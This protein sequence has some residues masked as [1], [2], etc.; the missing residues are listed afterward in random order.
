M[1][2]LWDE[3]HGKILLDFL[4]KL[5]DEKIRYFIIRGFEGLPNKNP[6]KDVDIMIEVGKEKQAALLLKKVYTNN[7][8]TNLH[9]DTFG[10]IHCYVG[11]DLVR[12]LSIHIDLVEGYISKGFEIFTFNE[13][14]EHVVQYNGM[15]VLDSY[16]NG[17]MLIVYKI[18]GYHKAKLKQSYRNEIGQAYVASRD[19]FA[20]EIYKICGNKIG[21]QVISCLEMNDFDQLLKLEPVF[22]KSLKQ[23]TWR[24][25][26]LKTLKYN[27]EFYIQ[28]I[29]RIIFFYRHYAKTFAVMAPD[30]TGKTTFLDALIDKLNYYYINTMEDNRFHVYHFRPSVLPNLGAVGEKAG[31]MKQDTN[32][33]NPHRNK[34]ANPFS[35]LVRISYYTLDYIFGWQKCVRNDVHYDRY[36]VFDR[37]SYDFIVDPLRTKLNLPK[38][39]RKFFV[40]LTPQPKIVFFLSASPSIVFA[41]KQE[42][43]L[44]EIERQS[45]EYLSLANSN[46]KRFKIINAEKTP[47]QMA[48]EALKIIVDLYTEK[49]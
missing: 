9:S 6:S 32:F 12:E 38:W 24:K 35:S 28:K 20:K 2:I 46:K 49:L 23:Y 10:H 16:M 4:A 5:N 36:S 11:M 26:F 29:N 8:I 7:G 41:R 27:L 13:L 25:Q 45:K 43:T 22:T 42:L 21:G 34:P 39:V 48:N 33:T 19:N 14:Y 37:Y 18:F 1:N 30:G 15:N 3:R 31:V 40:G 47:D 17:L 44:D